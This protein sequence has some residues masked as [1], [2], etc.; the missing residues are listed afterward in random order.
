MAT[1]VTVIFLVVALVNL[2]PVFG[3]ASKAR[4]E[5]LYGVTLD[6]PNLVVLM[7]HRAILLGI[8]GALLAVA[9]FEEPLRPTAIVAGFISM[10]SFVLIAYLAPGT[11]AELR[12]VARV[13]IVAS[14]LLAGAVVV[15]YV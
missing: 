11:N 13:D 15:M 7:R 4:L 6:D 3:V 1:L 10:L 9:A 5:L 12:R 14:V 8:V 2:L